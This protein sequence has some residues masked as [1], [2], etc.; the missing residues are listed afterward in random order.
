MEDKLYFL[1]NLKKKKKNPQNKSLVLLLGSPSQ[2]LTKLHEQVHFNHIWNATQTWVSVAALWEL[3]SRSVL[4]TTQAAQSFYLASITSQGTVLLSKQVCLL[5][6]PGWLTV[7]ASEPVAAHPHSYLSLKT[8]QE[9]WG[10][11]SAVKNI[12]C[13]CRKPG[14]S[15]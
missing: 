6:L 4:K 10:D 13:S 11:A 7:Q 15:S 3:F 2:T 5:A 1:P 14:S 9:A 8:D 12:R